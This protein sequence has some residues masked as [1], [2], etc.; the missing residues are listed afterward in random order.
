[1]FKYF[2][3]RLAQMVVT[4]FIVSILVFVLANFI[5]D[6][7][8][9]LVSPK[10]PP[11]VREQVREELGL[12]RPIL[13]QYVS[14]VTNALKGDFGKSYIYKVDVLSLIAQRVPATLELVLVSVVLALV[15]SIPL[16]VYAGAFPK[17]KSSTLVMGGSIL[18][19]SLPSFFIGIMLIYIFSLKLHWFPSSGRGATIPFLGMNFSLFAPGG[20]KYI[21]LPAFTL[22][23]TNI[24]SLVRLTRAGVMENMRQ[25]YIKFARAKGVSTRK[26]L[27]G[28]ALKNALIPVIT[29]F[30]M[31]IGSLIAFTTVTET[32]YSWPGLGKLLIDSIN[33]VDRPIIVA[34][35]IL[36][37]VL[38]VFIN[39]VVD[40]L[41]TVIDPRIEFR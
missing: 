40:L 6:P 8:N 32:I 16:G 2:L 9:M 21:I 4:L 3:K 17:R 18:G 13:E 41:Y 36:T 30:G 22:S 38:F 26:V 1:M 20:L 37:T 15:I 33:S 27:F 29:V 24:A 5:G 25:D 28:H 11:E 31:E 35:L 19:I 7:V 12:N 34:Y 23:V 39:F 14:F 10:A